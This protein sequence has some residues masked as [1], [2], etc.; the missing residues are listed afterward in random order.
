MAVRVASRARQQ[1]SIGNVMVVLI[2]DGRANVSLGQ[3]N[4]DPEALAPGAPAPSQQQ[5]QEEVLDM[6]RKLQG[7]GLQLL[8]IDT[9]GLGPAVPACL[10]KQLLMLLWRRVACSLALRCF[11]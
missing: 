5:I 2:T 11:V 3:S 9:G 6:A 10:K 1:G 8:V 7:A 4:E